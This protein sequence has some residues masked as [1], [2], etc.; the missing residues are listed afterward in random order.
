[1]LGIPLIKIYAKHIYLALYYVYTKISCFLDVF[2]KR[3][4]M[5]KLHGIVNEVFSAVI[6]Y[7]GH[8]SN[9]PHMFA[10]IQNCCLKFASE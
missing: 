4:E 3:V 7:S 8:I 2:L 10:N 1:M 9:F 5:S 6:I